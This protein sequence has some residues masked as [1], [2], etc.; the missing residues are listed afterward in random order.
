MRLA[1]D[2]VKWLPAAGRVCGVCEA[3]AVLARSYQEQNEFSVVT[4]DETEKTKEKQPP[5]GCTAMLH[6]H[7]II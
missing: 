2:H 4:T 7:R 3:T 1:F 6:G 5:V